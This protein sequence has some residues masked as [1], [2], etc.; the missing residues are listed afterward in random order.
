MLLEKIIK[1]AQTNWAALIVF[2]SKKHGNF[3]FCVNLR[4]LNTMTK[5]DPCPI[6]HMDKCIDLIGGEIVFSALDVKH[7]F[8]AD[9]N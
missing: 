9:Q 2:V 5:R 6:P 4:K 7:R 3:K 1:P 8:F